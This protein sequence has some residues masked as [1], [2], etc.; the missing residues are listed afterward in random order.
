MS[1]D[2]LAPHYRWME[3]VLAGNKLQRCRTALLDHARPAKRILIA[4]EGNGRFLLECRRKFPH[5]TITVLDASL[6]MLERARMRLRK[7]GLKS[8]DIEYI[9]LD[10]LEWRPAK[11]PYDLLVTHFFLDCFSE[12]ELRVVV[13]RMTEAA[14][15]DAKWLLADFQNPRSGW[16]KHRAKLINALMYAFFRPVTKL[17]AKR[18]IEPGPFMQA[19][20]F[21]RL[22]S[23]R[24]DCGLLGSELW[25][26]RSLACSAETQATGL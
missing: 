10:I 15:K 11:E 9:H 19:A 3:W 7:S 4:G 2:V 13:S 8:E 25:Q 17:S 26:R 23:R 1:F 12:A 5:A 16:R 22:E 18:L 24:F 21:A 14:S 20:G 6:R